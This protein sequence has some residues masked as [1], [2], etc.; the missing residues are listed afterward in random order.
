MSK[1]HG[2]FTHSNYAR[3]A[4]VIFP[5]NYVKIKIITLGNYVKEFYRII[6]GIPAYK[7]FQIHAQTIDASI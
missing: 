1:L 5:E 2:Q 4:G 6:M 3:I 7:C